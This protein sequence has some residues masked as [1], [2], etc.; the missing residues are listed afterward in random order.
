MDHTVVD[1]LGEP[2]QKPVKRVT[3]SSQS[4]KMVKRLNDFLSL[5]DL[6]R[7]SRGRESLQLPKTPGGCGQIHSSEFL[8]V[9]EDRWIFCPQ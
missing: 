7:Y 6:C 1:R 8:T 3:F 5:L 4:I 2:I 9:Y